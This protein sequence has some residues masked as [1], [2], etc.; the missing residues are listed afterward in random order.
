MTKNE[1][2]VEVFH[3][4]K[5]PISTIKVNIDLIKDFYT[6]NLDRNF[7]VIE[8]ELI[9]IDNII[10]KYL[11]F[12]DVNEASKDIIYFNEVISSIFEDNAITYPD[13]IF[14]VNCD[15]DIYIL[16]YE[17]HIYMIFSNIIKN[18][19]EAMNGVG[20]ITVNITEREGI[21]E[22]E[23]IDD[24]S[25]ITDNV[26]KR[27]QKGQYT[28]KPNGTGIGT[29]II[30][31]IVKLYNGEFNLLPQPIGTKAVVRIPQNI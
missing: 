5:N 15:S 17:Y 21:A 30:N 6:N 24:G 2:L 14:S 27:L 16:G 22:I 13:V 7:E 26:I 23:V 20:N 8:N 3:E 31:N 9:R 25:G 19:I 29:V 12:S 1:N 4:L 11:S 10:K 18:A 28:T